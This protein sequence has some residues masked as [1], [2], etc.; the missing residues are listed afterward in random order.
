MQCPNCGVPMNRHA[1]KIIK[2]ADLAEG[3]AVTS[4]HYCPRCGKVEAE[5]E[6]G[7]D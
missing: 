2:N 4:I 6:R 7:D 5:I 1:E 3:E